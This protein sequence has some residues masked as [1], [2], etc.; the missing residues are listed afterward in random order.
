[1]P[2]DVIRTDVALVLAKLV[3]AA[4]A[5]DWGEDAPTVAVL[6]RASEDPDDLRLAL[7]RIAGSVESELE[8]FADDHCLAAAH[9]TVERHP[10]PELTHHHDGSPVRV[11]V[12]I[13][14]D[15]QAGIVRHRNGS[16]EHF[17]DADLLLVKLLR[18]ALPPLM[19][20]SNE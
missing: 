3:D 13:D 15:G 14:H 20:L 10:P 19:V 12:A 2:D 16:L 7:K 18:T 11:T 17:G 8:V 1:M 6:C 4:L 5:D 9:S